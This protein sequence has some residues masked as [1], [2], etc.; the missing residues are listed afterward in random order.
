MITDDRRAFKRVRHK[1]VV[2]YETCAADNPATGTAV[3][4]N[5]S[6]GGVYFLSLE[7]IPVGTCLYCHIDLPDITERGKWKARVVRCEEVEKGM[8]KTYG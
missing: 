6:K 3:T 4:E 8:I 7:K 2:R 5:I 1:F